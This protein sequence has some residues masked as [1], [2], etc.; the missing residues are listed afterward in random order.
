M[1]PLEL[2]PQE[3]TAARKLMMATW[4]P[5]NDPTM[6]AMLEVTMDGAL[7]YLQ[8]FRE[9]TGRRV[10]V[11]HLTAR[12]VAEA[13]RRTPEAN[14]LVA[15]GRIYRRRSIGVSMPVL[16]TEKN[17][18]GSERLE[19][20]SVIIED[21]AEKDLAQIADEISEKVA[22]VRSR[23]DLNQERL[24]RGLAAVPCLLIGLVLRLFAFLVFTLRLDLTR[25]GVPRDPYGSVNITNVGSI[26]LDVGFAPLVPYAR[27]PAVFCTGAVQARPVVEDG[28]IVIRQRMTITLT[29]DHR[30]I[31]GS[32]LALMFGTLREWLEKPHEHFGEIPPG[33]GA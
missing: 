11:T 33:E 2:E 12:A 4:R 7:D 30:V 14:A 23:E 10:T 17:A 9:A 26:G 16:L 15:R 13:L 5:S 27:F 18:D 25:F 29:A 24:R 19:L 21:A 28:Q 6:Y 22:A 31:D 8:R 3:Q 20:A 1:S 32:H